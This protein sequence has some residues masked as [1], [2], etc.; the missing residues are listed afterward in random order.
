MSDHLSSPSKRCA[1]KAILG[2]RTAEEGVEARA[3]AALDLLILA[4]EDELCAKRADR[5]WLGLAESERGRKALM[6]A[7]VTKFPH[8]DERFCESDAFRNRL[9]EL[10]ETIIDEEEMA[11]V[12]LWTGLISRIGDRLPSQFTE[13]Y[14]T[15]LEKILLARLE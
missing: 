1:L 6:R 12:R 15:F 11:V 4:G 7:A 14:E 3:E 8:L 2:K 10:S 9:V 13:E 5:L